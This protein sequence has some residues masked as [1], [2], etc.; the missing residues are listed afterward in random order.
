MEKLF[1]AERMSIILSGNKYTFLK[2][3]G[4]KMKTHVLVVRQHMHMDDTKTEYYNYFQIMNYFGNDEGGQILSYM[5]R[6][7]PTFKPR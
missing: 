4:D 5:S 3:Y 1:L 7:T 2:P 6:M